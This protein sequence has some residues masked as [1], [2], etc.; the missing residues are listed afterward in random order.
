MRKKF[1]LNVVSLERLSLLVH[2]GFGVG[3]TH[4]VGDALKSL[5]KRGPVRFINIAGEDGQM[6]LAPHGLGEVGETVET[7]KDLHEALAEYRKEGVVG[8]GVDSLHWLSRLVMVD[9]LGSDRLPVTGSKEAAGE[10]GQIH[11]EMSNLIYKI[12]DSVPYFIATCP[13][14]RS[15]D[16]LRGRTSEPFITPDLPGRQAAGSAGWFDFAGYIITEVLPRGIKRTLVFTPTSTILIR[17]RIPETLPDIV[18]GE[19]GGGWDRFLA[20]VTK[21]L[22]KYKEK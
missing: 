20:E 2:G 18:L 14:D 10:W 11:R 12:R 8:L 1:N 5:S 6:S 13:S 17:Q 7:V 9:V 21:I 22:D 3:K 16:Q 4:F 19:G 15:V